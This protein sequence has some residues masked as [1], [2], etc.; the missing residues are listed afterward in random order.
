M[1]TQLRV[2]CGHGMHLWTEVPGAIEILLGWNGDA[3]NGKT[4]AVGHKSPSSADILLF[5]DPSTVNPMPA[6]AFKFLT[7]FFDKLPVVSMRLRQPP[8]HEGDLFG[9]AGRTFKREPAPG[10]QWIRAPAR[11]ERENVGPDAQ[12]TS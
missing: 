8:Q 9:I 6:N 3:G 12:A 7:Q 4:S 11:Q 5:F 2:D 1:D 10:R